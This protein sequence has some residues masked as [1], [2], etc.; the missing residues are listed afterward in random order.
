MKKTMKTVSDKVIEDLN[1]MDN[2]ELKQMIIIA[3]KDYCD[4]FEKHVALL[5]ALVL[6]VIF[7]IVLLISL[8]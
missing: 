3:Y 5:I 7:N 8:T 1:S 4:L 6:S 2:T